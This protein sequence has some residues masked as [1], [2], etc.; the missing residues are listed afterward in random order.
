MNEASPERSNLYRPTDEDLQRIDRLGLLDYWDAAEIICS[1]TDLRIFQ[2]F[3][4][5]RVFVILR[6]QHRLQAMAVSLDNLRQ[7]Q[8]RGEMENIQN[9][10]SLDTLTAKIEMTLK[11]YGMQMS[12]R[13]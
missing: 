1:D 9:D 8:I 5:L 2:R 7:R 13:F 6:L 12:R 3:G 11:D 4:E 10:N